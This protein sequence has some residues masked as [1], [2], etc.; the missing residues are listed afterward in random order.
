MLRAV[1]ESPRRSASKARANASFSVICMAKRLG[2]LT[3]RSA[4]GQQLA[5]VVREHV[6]PL[7]VRDVQAQASLR[8]EHVRAGRMIHRVRAGARSGYLLVDDLELLGRARRRLG[9]TVDAEKARV[10]RG[11]VLREQRRRVAL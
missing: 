11:D 7:A 4:G 8:I 3:V 10:E 9:V 5:E 2:G 1:R 6:G